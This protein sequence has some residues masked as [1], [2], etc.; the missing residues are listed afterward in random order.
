MKATA[1]T[2]WVCTVKA[3]EADPKRH[4]AGERVWEHYAKEAPRKWLDDGL[5]IDSSEYVRE[6]QMEIFDL[7]EG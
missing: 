3:Q 6:G 5:I 1:R 4:R 7:L 2:H